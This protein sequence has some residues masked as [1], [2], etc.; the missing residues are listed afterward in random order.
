LNLSLKGDSVTLDIPDEEKGFHKTVQ[1]KNL[2]FPTQDNAPF[3]LQKK[4]WIQINKLINFIS[5]STGDISG[6]E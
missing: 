5:V 4:I 3:M 2:L 6:L 1:I